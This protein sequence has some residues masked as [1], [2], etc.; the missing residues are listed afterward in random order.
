MN[1]AA[2]AY[3]FYLIGSSDNPELNELVVHYATIKRAISENSFDS[4]SLYQ[5]L[6]YVKRR[7]SE[8]S[9]TDTQLNQNLF[10]R[11]DVTTSPTD[12]TT[13][14][15]TTVSTVTT[16]VSEVFP[17]S[18][19]LTSTMLVHLQQE[20][21]VIPTETLTTDTPADA[22]TS[23]SS[24]I[25]STAL[26]ASIMV[27]LLV[28]GSVLLIIRRR[29][30]TES[31]KGSGRSTVETDID[32][33]AGQVNDMYKS[34][35]SGPPFD[36]NAMLPRPIIKKVSTLTSE[37][38]KDLSRLTDPAEESRHVR[39]ETMLNDSAKAARNDFLRLSKGTVQSISATGSSPQCVDLE[40]DGVAVQDLYKTKWSSPSADKRGPMQNNNQVRGVSTLTSGYMLEDEVQNEMAHRFSVMAASATQQALDDVLPDRVEIEE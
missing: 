36:G 2:W 23:S 7:I 39:F 8:I 5:K 6:I 15:I 32:L 10:E 26:V 4:E 17:K 27:T 22:L 25:L 1:Y 9:S 30:S 33:E 13:S 18:S 24:T 38:S 40:V 16:D 28:I 3:F 19:T 35:W 11:R 37:S 14:A 29:R 34:D 21:H 31:A 12:S 20:T